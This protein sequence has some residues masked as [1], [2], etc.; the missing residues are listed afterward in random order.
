MVQLNCSFLMKLSIQEFPHAIKEVCSI[1][2]EEQVEELHVKE[3]L[4]RLKAHEGDLQFMWKTRN[5]H[6]LTPVL[7]EQLR[8]RKK[9]LLGLRARIKAIKK[10]PD[11]EERD[12]AKIVYL[13]INKH[14]DYIYSLSSVVQTR[15]VDNLITEM[16]SVEEIGVALNFLNLTSVFDSIK[17][18]SIE[19]SANVTKR[20]DDTEKSK[21][22]A[23]E[24]KRAVYADFIS[25]LW[26]LQTAIN[27]ES[28]DVGF[29]KGYEWK[30]E[31]RLDKYRKRLALRS[32]LRKKMQNEG[33]IADDG[34][35]GENSNAAEQP[36]NGNIRLLNIMPTSSNEE[37]MDNDELSSKN[38]I[39]QEK[40]SRL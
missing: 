39:D 4:S 30:I 40:E 29:Y 1:Y 16:E 34:V 5:P 15:L 35:V 37:E 3:S 8:E 18:L 9:Y 20:H 2:D 32:T 25:F 13:W 19:I 11:K 21:R 6:L 23:D 38:D 36:E 17:M 26:S 27:L 14:R 31:S 7:Q 22:Q 12:A 33:D 10:S 28:P 24:I